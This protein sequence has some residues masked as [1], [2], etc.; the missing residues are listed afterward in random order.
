M[1][2]ESIN[3]RVGDN[4]RVLGGTDPGE[5]IQEPKS[6]DWD[7]LRVPQDIL[8]S[9]RTK[10]TITQIPVRKP[11]KHE[12]IRVHP[13]PA[14]WFEP[15]MLYDD[16]N[17]RGNFYLV[18]PHCYDALTGHMQPF[19][20]Y[21]AATRFGSMILWPARLPG[22][23]GTLNPWHESARECAKLAMEHWCRLEANA[24]IQGYDVVH[25]LDDD[26]EPDWTALE[27]LGLEKVLEIAFRR[28][29]IE[30]DDHP[31]IMSLRGEA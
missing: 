12:F 26:L 2:T 24:D 25:P 22:V 6:R 28:R 16:P 20:L 5:A 21:A 30:D 31:L 27:A 17:S 23:D 29:I 10:K 4:G 15:A 18:H 9:S 11:K 1:S 8:G 19:S 3:S 14:F 13:N 7:K